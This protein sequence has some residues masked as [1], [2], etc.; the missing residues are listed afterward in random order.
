M[1]RLNILTFPDP[2]LRKKA[3]PITTFDKDLEKKADD[4]LFTMYEDKGIGLA[5]TQV[6]IHERLI[7]MDLTEDRSDPL[8]IVNPSYEILDDSLEISK[9]GCLSI[10]TFQQEVP[11][12]KEIELTYQDLKGQ[13]QKLIADGLLGYCIQ[14]EIDH[15]NGKLLVDYASS[16]KRSRIKEK[17]MKSKDGKTKIKVGFAGT[18]KIAFDIFSEILSS[19]DISTEFVLTQPDKSSGR[20]LVTSKSLF[21]NIDNVPV[22]QPESLSGEELIKKIEAFNIDLLVVVAYGK[23]LPSWLLNTPKFGCLNI[24]FSNLPKYRGAAP[25]QR[26]IENGEKETG[27]SFMKLTEGLDEGPIYKNIVINIENKDYF[28]VESLLLEESLSSV[29]DVIK[30]VTENLQPKEQ[31]HS[32]ATLANKITKMK[33]KLIGLIEEGK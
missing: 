29:C 12:A 16:L 13:K 28:E 8:I 25:I 20:G 30:A 31:D 5:A 22:L 3:V 26:A 24:H 19:K 23:I 14:H 6:N 33:G 21:A 17:L 2:R 10:P 4:M 1:N 18:P 11:R 32:L 15:L 27:I 7:V 9:E